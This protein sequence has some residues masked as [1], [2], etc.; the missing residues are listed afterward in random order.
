MIQNKTATEIL[1]AKF[2][3]EVWALENMDTIIKGLEYLKGNG[4]IGKRQIA[5][6]FNGIGFP[7]FLEESR[8]TDSAEALPE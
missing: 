8:T 4:L 3:P 2:R 6:V 1:G 5:Q 7:V